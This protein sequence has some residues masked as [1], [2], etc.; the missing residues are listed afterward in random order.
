MSSSSFSSWFLPSR[1]AAVSAGRSPRTSILCDWTMAYCSFSS[2][3]NA[4]TAFV[5]AEDALGAG[6]SV[7]SVPHQSHMTNTHHVISR[8]KG[9]G[10]QRGR[11]T[12]L[13]MLS[14]V[15]LELY[16]SFMSFKEEGKFSHE[17]ET[18]LAQHQQLQFFCRQGRCSD[19]VQMS[20]SFAF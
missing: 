9:L 4:H 12:A 16:N 10:G 19:S 15:N 7:G 11:Y 1:H 2:L 17:S 20:S 13:T 14:F 8:E 18:D 5:L 3:T 6:S